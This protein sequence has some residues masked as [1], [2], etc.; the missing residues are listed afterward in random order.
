MRETSVLLL[1]SHFPWENHIFVKSLWT[2]HIRGR[3]SSAALIAKLEHC[4]VSANF[5]GGANLQAA[6]VLITT[7]DG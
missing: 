6:G 5:L 7:S 2:F 1:P 4:W 3:S